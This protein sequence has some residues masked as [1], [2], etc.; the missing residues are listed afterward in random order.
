M[1]S[2]T[3][4][5]VAI[6]EPQLASLQDFAQGGEVLAIVPQRVLER[7]EACLPQ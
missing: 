5:C 4:G 3:G 6:P 1:A 7:F 2:G